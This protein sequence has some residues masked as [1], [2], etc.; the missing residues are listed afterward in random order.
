MESALKIPN[1]LIYCIF[2]LYFSPLN[3]RL[4]KTHDYVEEPQMIT[5]WCLGFGKGFGICGCFFF[6]PLKVCE[7]KLRLP[8]SGTMRLEA[9]EGS[10][11]KQRTGSINSKSAQDRDLR[12]GQE[13]N[14][15]RGGWKM[16]K[17]VGICFE[18]CR[19]IG[20]RGW[21]SPE[22]G[23]GFSCWRC[24]SPEEGRVRT[25]CFGKNPG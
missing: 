8:G 1:S 3:Q 12:D 19:Q 2:T 9:R 14:S 22:C 20:L 16:K 13:G 21:E 11:C 25:H 24:H 23:A 10:K 18:F 4:G 17:E 7:S 6:F 15:S 5:L